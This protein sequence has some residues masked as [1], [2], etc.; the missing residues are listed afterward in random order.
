MKAGPNH[1]PG[2]CFSLLIY[3]CLALGWRAQAQSWTNTAL[4]AGQRAS[5]LLSNTTLS[6]EVTMVAGAG[7]SYVGNIP[8]NSRLGIPALNLQDGPAGI[9]DG[10]SGGTDP[11]GPYTTPLLTRKKRLISCAKVSGLMGFSI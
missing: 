5:L 2:G 7:G 8:A 3:L 11:N 9:G 4:P 1:F 10:V 6:D